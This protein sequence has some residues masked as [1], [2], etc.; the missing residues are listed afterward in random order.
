M[1]NLTYGNI[2]VPARLEFTVVGAAANE[3][4]RLEGLCKSLHESVLI[5]SE[6]EHCIPGKLISLGFQRLRGVSAAQEVF[7]LPDEKATRGAEGRDI[8]STAEV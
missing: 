2:G 5:S 7:T 4:V 1:G 8:D 6:F 3:A